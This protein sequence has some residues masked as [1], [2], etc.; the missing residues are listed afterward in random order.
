[1]RWYGQE[2]VESP[3]E[4]G[5]EPSGRM[6]SWENSGVDE[7]LATCLQRASFHSL[8][9]QCQHR[10]TEAS[11]DLTW[12]KRCYRMKAEGYT[13]PA[14]GLMYSVIFL[15]SLLL[16]TA[17]YAMLYIFMYDIT[18]IKVYQN[19]CRDLGQLTNENRPI[20]TAR[21]PKRR[22]RFLRVKHE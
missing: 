3:R 22:K 14:S 4:H 17:A 5:N 1:M 8:T 10:L 18:S 12:Q 2:P 11:T 6:K 13:L 19:K 7:R 15:H 9:E 20:P 21:R 16:S